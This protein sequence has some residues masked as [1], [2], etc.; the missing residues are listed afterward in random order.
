[1]CLDRCRR[2]CSAGTDNEYIYVVIYFVKVDVN[3]EDT[4]VGLQQIAEL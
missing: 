1:M 4:A 3:T 2:T